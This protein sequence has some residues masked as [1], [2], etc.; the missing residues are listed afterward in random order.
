MGAVGLAGVVAAEAVVEVEVSR[1]PFCMLD[2]FV[3]VE[4]KILSSLCGICDCMAAFYSLL[5]FLHGI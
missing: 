2:M 3:A 5:S 1:H 4:T